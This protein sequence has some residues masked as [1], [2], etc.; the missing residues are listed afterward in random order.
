MHQPVPSITA[1]TSNSKQVRRLR[2]IM[3]A[4]GGGD[5][6]GEAVVVFRHR[7][8]ELIENFLRP[9]I[10]GEPLPS[11]A[12]NIIH[13]ADV[14]K[15]PPDELAAR[16]APAPGTAVWYFFSPVHYHQG[17]RCRRVPC[18]VAGGGLWWEMGY[19]EKPVKGSVAGAYQQKLTYYCST[20]PRPEWRMVEYCIPQEDGSEEQMILCK[21][22]RTREA[23]LP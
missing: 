20:R 13:D 23:S 12:A 10:A 16:H 6:D 15:S 5:Q 22:F 3:A 21:V 17:C 9:K 8:R 18:R 7:N 1:S 14:Y 2:S 4:A 11:A 19:V